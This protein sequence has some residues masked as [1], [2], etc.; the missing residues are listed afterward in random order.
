[1]YGVLCRLAY[2]I[3]QFRVQGLII[4][5]ILAGKKGTGLEKH[6]AIQS[7]DNSLNTKW[8]FFIPF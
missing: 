5:P 2:D 3:I 6:H 7:L 1:M 8:I 4:E